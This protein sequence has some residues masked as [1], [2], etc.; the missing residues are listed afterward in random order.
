MLL[1]NLKKDED[2]TVHAFLIIQYTKQTG[3]IFDEQY[4]V[5]NINSSVLLNRQ[6]SKNDNISIL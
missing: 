3:K 1:Y 6:F 2:N 5:S 4:L